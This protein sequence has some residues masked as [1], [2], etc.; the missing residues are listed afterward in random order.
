MVTHHVESHSAF[1][2]ADDL[3]RRRI[4]RAEPPENGS[5]SLNRRA[6]EA[7]EI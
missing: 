2:V 7:A 3:E 6:A 1:G 5:L 4:E